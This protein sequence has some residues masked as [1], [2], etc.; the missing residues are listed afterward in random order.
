MTDGKI[1]LH[2]DGTESKQFDIRDGTGVVWAQRAGLNVGI[3]SARSSAAT[4]HR[5]AQLGISIIHQG[6]LNKLRS[7]DEL[8]RQHGVTDAQV[9]YMGDD[10]LDLPV[11]R[12]VGLSA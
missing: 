6:G 12:R 4:T 7:Y 11:V 1:L 5:A 10:L 9:A 8:L 2:A 3:L